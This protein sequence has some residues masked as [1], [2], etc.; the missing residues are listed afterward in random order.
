MII[1]PPAKKVTVHLYLVTKVY[2]QF[3]KYIRRGTVGSEVGLQSLNT[4]V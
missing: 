2:P 4:L 1:L 3:H